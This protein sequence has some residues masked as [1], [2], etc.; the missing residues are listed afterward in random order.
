VLFTFLIFAKHALMNRHY[1]VKVALELNK[2]GNLTSK[3]TNQAIKD[4]ESTGAFF[5]LSIIVINMQA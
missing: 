1:I 2:C 4:W 5:L 3:A